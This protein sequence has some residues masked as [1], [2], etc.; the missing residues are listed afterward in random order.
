[1]SFSTLDEKFNGIWQRS[2]NLGAL[3]S[4]TPE[5]IDKWACDK[6]LTNS[7][8]KLEDVGLF[9]PTPCITLSVEGGKACFP[10][11]PVSG[12]ENWYIRRKQH[13][14]QAALWDKVEW[15]MPL[16]LP[17]GE[18]AKLLASVQNVTRE[19]ALEL[20]QYHTSTLY[21]LA[22]QAV[23]IEQILPL[24]NS[25]KE[26]VP[27]VREAY[28]GAYS[29]Y[30]ATSIGALI[31]AIEGSLTRIV[32]DIGS[33]ASASE[34]IDHAVKRAIGTAAEL[35]FEGMWVPEEYKSCNYLFGQDERVFAFETFRRWLKNHFFCNTEK[36]RG[37]TWLNRHM[38][39]HGTAA[40]WQKPANFARMVVAL[41]TLATI[42]SWYDASH[43][44]SLSFP[45]MNEDSTLLWQQALFRGNVQMKM[46]LTEQDYFREHGHLVPPL[47]ADDGISLRKGLLSQQC[48][49]DL[50]R[51]LRDAG[52]SV[53]VNE[54]DSQA[55]Y[56]I[57]EASY[58]EMFLSVAL[59]YSCG[60]ENRIYRMLAEKCGAILYCGP[61]YKQDAFAYGISV[62]VGPVLG[63]QPPKVN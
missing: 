58:G 27:L 4:L 61:P 48:M 33:K 44:V 29:G 3:S 36:Y 30:W 25:L 22:F 54:P 63:W 23:C 34:K 26:I 57:V 43:R 28:L 5:L 1:M 42:E 15:F 12:D 38:F 51:P 60:T 10:T 9:Y 2:L 7:V 31:P 55:L 59:L 46:K 56:M 49:N 19:R 11:I 62:H 16:W 20:F 21:T 47:P 13:D 24:A 41:A 45:S 18:V 53:K 8:V 52:W 37:M 40:S 39:A 50:V 32:S 14:E 17:M 35:H 6:K